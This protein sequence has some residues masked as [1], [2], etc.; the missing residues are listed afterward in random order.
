MKKERSIINVKIYVEM[1]KTKQNNAIYI[2]VYI[3]HTRETFRIFKYWKRLDTNDQQGFFQQAC[4]TLGS[5]KHSHFLFL[6]VQLVCESSL[7]RVAELTFCLLLPLL[8]NAIQF[9]RRV[10][11]LPITDAWECKWGRSPGSHTRASWARRLPRHWPRPQVV[12]RQA[13]R[14][15][16]WWGCKR[17]IMH[18]SNSRNSSR[19]CQKSSWSG[20]RAF[21]VEKIK[22]VLGAAQSPAPAP[23]KAVEGGELRVS[24]R[25]SWI[26]SPEVA[27]NLGS[28]SSFLLRLRGSD[29][30]RLR[31]LQNWSRP[32]T[33]AC[34]G[35]TWAMEPFS[36]PRVAH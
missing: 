27:T 31:H 33:T 7:D 23:R 19:I 32:L 1:F 8:L 34:G 11:S 15:K 26:G 2:Y 22:G 16:R 6:S 10:M 13:R 29:L 20:E 21:R 30:L 28:C 18:F 35:F 4:W 12:R 14:G 24:H 9:P 3:N 25:L 17:G 36:A 5:V